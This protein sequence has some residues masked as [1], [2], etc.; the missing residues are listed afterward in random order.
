MLS[1]GNRK[2]SPLEHMHH[3]IGNGVQLQITHIECIAHSQ[4]AVLHWLRRENFV[5]NNDSDLI[6][7]Q[8]TR[9]AH[10]QHKTLPICLTIL[11]SI[12]I[13]CEFA[14]TR[15]AYL[16]F[17][18]VWLA[19]AAAVAA[20]P[21]QQ[22]YIYIC[23]DGTFISINNIP[24]DSTTIQRHI[25]ILGDPS[26]VAFYHIIQAKPAYT[27]AIARIII[28]LYSARRFL[29]SLALFAHLHRLDGKPNPSTLRAVCKYN[30]NNNQVMIY[31]ID[32]LPF[33]AAWL[34]WTLP[35]LHTAHTAHTH[36][37]SV[38]DVWFCILRSASDAIS[39]TSLSA[40]NR[41]PC[42]AALNVA[43][44]LNRPLAGYSRLKC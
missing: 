13:V 9:H 28:L 16:L 15:R 32:S 18:L 21:I 8:R 12:A 31:D 33:A 36:T 14:T 3:S 43:A 41:V 24:S 2:H 35:T 23:F 37:R 40:P 42:A 4:I 5:S 39:S 27:R 25:V 44:T 19:T 38:A 26:M 22:L 10:T 29:S 7:K 6:Y 1:N 30:N 11:I 34:L 17:H 20:P